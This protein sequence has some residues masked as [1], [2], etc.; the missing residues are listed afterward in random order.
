M[1]SFADN[2]DPL[3]ISD[4]VPHF[5]RTEM[6]AAFRPVM[7]N[8]QRQENTRVEWRTIVISPDVAYTIRINDVVQVDLAGN[9]GPTVRYAETIL[10]VRRDGEWKALIGH[11]STPNEST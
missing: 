7:E 10:W 11:G 9:A 2:S 6:E 3:W 1:D 8:M 5:G 4:A